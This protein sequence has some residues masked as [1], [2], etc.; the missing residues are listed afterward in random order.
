MDP[1]KIKSECFILDV[2]QGSAQ[3]IAL[4]SGGV[5]L[6]DCGKR[7]SYRVLKRLM[8]RYKDCPIER[9]IVTHN[10]DDHDGAA[11]KLFPEFCRRVQ[12]IYFLH[13][14]PFKDILLWSVVQ[15]EEARLK[16]VWPKVRLEW[17][18]TNRSLYADTKNGVYLDV[19]APSFQQ[20][21][22]NI[23]NGN[24]MSGVLLLRCGSRKIVFPGDSTTEEWRDINN[25]LGKP[26]DCDVMVVPHHGALLEDQAWLY[27][28][29]VRPKYGV[30]SAGSSN[31]FGKEVHPHPDTVKALT[32]VGCKVLCTQIT[33]H[34]SSDLEKLRPGLVSAQFASQSNPEEQKN[35]SGRSKNVGCATTVL[36]EIGDKSVEVR[37]FAEH[38][39]AINA[40]VGQADFHPLCR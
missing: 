35:K 36:V 21:S 28:Q 30:I 32:G 27:T 25:R 13:D 37:P 20:A 34:C 39:K 1:A 14:R 5:I 2:G 38:Q 15:R 11:A 24:A 10:D 29:A 8:Q 18:Q 31:R 17:S 16:K 40:R 33:P 19:L 12:K 9:L 4:P 6:I 3:V 22:K 23:G 7:G 26:L